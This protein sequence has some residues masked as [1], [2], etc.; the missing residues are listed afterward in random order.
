MRSYGST[1]AASSSI[2][3]LAYRPVVRS[4]YFLRKQQKLRYTIDAQSLLDSALALPHGLLQT[5]H[6]FGFS[7]TLAIPIS[8]LL[9][10]AFIYFPLFGIPNQRLAQRR[11]EMV[12][13]AQAWSSA[14]QVSVKKDFVAGKVGSLEDA[15]RLSKNRLHAR[16]KELKKDF[17]VSALSAFRPLLQFPVFYVFAEAIRRMAGAQ[18][19][20]LGL[21]ADKISPRVVEDVVSGSSVGEAGRAVINSFYEPSMAAEGALW[22][23]NLTLADPTHNLSFLISAVTFAH[24][25][26]TSR[27]STSRIRKRIFLSLS[28]FIAPLTF[29]LPS[30]V[31]LY[32]L[33]STSGAILQ[34]LILDYLYP[35]RKPITK[36]KRQSSMMSIETKDSFKT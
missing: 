35:L 15:N 2:L 6:S 14:V 1:R 13:L 4:Q 32:W 30:A 17:G 26:S 24:I 36:C 3:Y 23:G 19:S 33:T 21:L 11:I 12:P 27:Q 9:V 8:A 25:W 10:R 34:E 22:F 20:L 18:S 31:L 28:I 7:W 5:I 16:M 29:N